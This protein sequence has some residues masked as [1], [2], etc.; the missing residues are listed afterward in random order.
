MD[1]CESS[2]SSRVAGIVSWTKT[3]MRDMCTFLRTFQSY[4]PPVQLHMAEQ[5]GWMKVLGE[6][7]GIARY[8]ALLP[9][10]GV[11]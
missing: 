7:E 10:D 6:R 1:K 11:V 2:A 5:V 3:Y 9:V 4:V 8:L